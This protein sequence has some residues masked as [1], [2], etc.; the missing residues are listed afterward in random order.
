MQHDESHMQQQQQ[1]VP[2]HRHVPAH[3]HHSHERS[4]LLTH[5]SI[6]EGPSSSLSPDELLPQEQQFHTPSGATVMETM[7]NLAK[8]C[9]GTGCLALPFAAKQGGI[10]LHI[11]GLLIIALWNVLASQRL[12]ACWDLLLSKT[13]TL[14]PPPRGTATLG[15]VAW[16]ALGGSTGLFVLDALT[17]ILLLGIIVAYNDAIR[18]FLQGTPMTTH[19]DVLDAIVIACLIAP[20][21]IVPDMG[22]L[23]KTSAAGLLVLAATL[24]V[25]ALYGIHTVSHDTHH[26]TITTTTAVTAAANSAVPT[27]SSWPWF[28]TNGL[29][30]ASQWFGCCVFGFGI[31]P[32]T[33]NFRESMAEPAKLP[34][35]TMAA[36]LLV[37]LTYM[38][39]GLGFLI[40]YPNIQAD[41]L[42]ELPHDGWIPILTR[43]AMVIVVMATSPLLI[44]PCGEI[45]EGK[46]LFHDDNDDNNDDDHVHNN[47]DNNDHHNNANPHSHHHH[48]KRQM[49]VRVGICILTVA[50]SVGI[51]EFVSVLTLVGCFC[52]AFVSFCIPPYLHFLILQQQGQQSWTDVLLLCFGLLAT[53]ISTTYVFEHSL[54]GK[55]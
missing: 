34:Q 29:A 12:S 11:F 36:L 5:A 37:A 17:V 2:I 25:V 38:F 44:V 39:I 54:Q 47:N 50:I 20:L 6:E 28:P 18:V 33:F 13:A 42:S 40:L 8:T 4:P 48:R 26:S 51:P 53:G 16:Y 41:V 49:M 1:Q 24:M 9:M 35:A 21:S 45:I 14:P 3:S 43:W 10:L 22:Y 55:A 32:L 30:G 15:K 19:S 23:T 52:V 27:I 46:L 31:V 7:T